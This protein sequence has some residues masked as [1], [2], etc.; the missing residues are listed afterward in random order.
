MRSPM[1]AGHHSPHIEDDGNWFFFY[2]AD[3]KIP[4]ATLVAG[5]KYDSNSELDRDGA[6][7]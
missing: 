1:T 4:F 3:N 2:D 6:F 7:D 5:N